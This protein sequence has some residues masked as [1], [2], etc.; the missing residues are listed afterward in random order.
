MK[1]KIKKIDIHTHATTWSSALQPPYASSPNTFWP[2][3]SEL[4]KML[5]DANID[6]AILLPL[7]SSEGRNLLI[8][9]EDT[10]TVCQSFKDRFYWFCGLDP[11]MVYNSEDSDLGYLINH[12]KSLGAKGVGELT[13]NLYTDEPLMDNLFFHC[14]QC[15]M[16]VIIHISP[17]PGVSYGIVDEIGL[18]RLE[19]TLKKYPKLKIIGHSQPFWAEIS[20]DL[21]EEKRNTY[22]SGKVKEGRLFNLLRDYENLYCDLS[23]GSG[24][25]AMTRDKE[26][27]V[28]FLTEFQDKVMFGTDICAPSNAHHIALS[29]FYD[30]LYFDDLISESIYKKICRENAIKTLGL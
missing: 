6:K 7:C 14:Q 4:V 17:A 19:K 25:N 30:N 29:E 10:Y 12:Y 24:L 1:T 26:S 2:T 13:A 20:A 3:G 11:R 22:P 28:R 15:D 23:A 18:P 21:T 27:A 5:D 16:P 8:T 9:S